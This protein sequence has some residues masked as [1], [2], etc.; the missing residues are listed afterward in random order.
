MPNSWLMAVDQS[1]AKR[2]TGASILLMAIIGGAVY[3]LIHQVLHSPGDPTGTLAA[4]NGNLG[5]VTLAA[6]SWLLV[7]LLDVV[8]S[9]GAFRL[10]RSTN[11]HLAMASACLRGAYAA[12]LTFAALLLLESGLS[13]NANTAYA[14]FAQFEFVWGVGLL[15]F[16][17]HLFCLGYIARQS[18]FTPDI[19]SWLLMCAGVC[20][21]ISRVVWLAGIE[22]AGGVILAAVMII[23]EF[24]FAVWLMA[25]KAEKT[26]AVVL[27]PEPDDN[28]PL[29]LLQVFQSVLWAAI[30]IQKHENRV[31]DFT[32]G[33][34][35]HFI[36]MGMAFTVAFVLGVVGV[37]HTILANH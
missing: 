30:G 23:G 25:S 6:T 29:T 13:G 37:V 12:V 35:I 36:L 1:T 33:N 27:K 22:V 24:T 32:R 18:E 5:L 9:L 16:G 4:V 20:Y 7:A 28:Q 10:Y 8:V 2:T 3:A 17:L 31:R 14:A 15:V 11:E 19:I 34:P 21:L 26:A